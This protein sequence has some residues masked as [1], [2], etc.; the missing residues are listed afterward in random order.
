MLTDLNEAHRQRWLKHVLNQLEDGSRILDAGAGECQN[1]VYCQHLVYVAQDFGQYKGTASEECA[2]EG[3]F[4]L[5]WD[6][7]QVDILSDILSIPEPDSSFD[8]ILCSEV[9]EHVPDPTRVLD[10]FKRLLKP[11]GKLILTAPF[12]S[13]THMAPYHF[14]TG[15]SK[16]WYDH[17]LKLR[18]F[19]I[20][21]LEANGDWH[22]FLRQE[23]TRLGG[24]ERDLK[25]WTWPIAYAFALTG[26]AYFAI[27][28]RTNTEDLACFGW[29]CVATLGN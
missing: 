1:R 14:C 9:L 21:T 17:H 4:Q 19:L 25:A 29:Q 24:L 18:G 6:T 2:K 11:G 15:F 12:M 26:L 16:Y 8:A 3:L 22:S 7:S 13:L 20:E 5:E 23:I 10:E 28:P 27:R